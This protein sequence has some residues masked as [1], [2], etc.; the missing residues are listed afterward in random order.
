V[1]SCPKCISAN[2]DPKPI[3]RGQIQGWRITCPVCE[4]PLHGNR[5][6]EVPSPLR[7]HWSSALR[8]PHKTPTSTQF[9]LVPGDEDLG[10]PRLFRE[11]TGRKPKSLV[12]R[13][14]P[15]SGPRLTLRVSLKRLNVVDSDQIRIMH[16]QYI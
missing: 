5:E 6:P 2:S 13:R 9:P 11:G 12:N 1:H 14:P 10:K 7:R 3:M 15:Q 4:S 16:A 8:G